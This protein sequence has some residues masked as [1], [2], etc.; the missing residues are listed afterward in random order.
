[1]HQLVN[2]HKAKMADLSSL[3]SAGSSAAYLPDSL[4]TELLN[5]VPKIEMGEGDYAP[6]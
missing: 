4:K 6:S 1:V 2:S 3:E 5:I